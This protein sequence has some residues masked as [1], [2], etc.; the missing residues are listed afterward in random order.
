LDRRD[1]GPLR[2]VFF[3]KCVSQSPEPT[4]QT[5]V[6][7]QGTM[8][9]FCRASGEQRAQSVRGGFMPSRQRDRSQT[10]LDWHV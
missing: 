10:G 6:G 5:V 3:L 7:G 1:H 2:G 9:G 4:A 8:L